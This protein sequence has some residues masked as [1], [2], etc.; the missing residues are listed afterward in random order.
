MRDERF[1][2]TK[3][4]IRVGR[5]L[6]LKWAGLTKRSSAIIGQNT[7]ELEEYVQ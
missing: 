4:A 2:Q 6:Y 3:G 5:C 7:F 1:W